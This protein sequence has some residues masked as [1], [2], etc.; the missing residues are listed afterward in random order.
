M[1]KLALDGQIAAARKLHY[2]L[3]D[4]MNLIFADGSPG[5][6]K[7]ILEAQNICDNIV[8]LPLHTVN[9]TVKQQLLGTMGN[10]VMAS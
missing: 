2:E 10:A 9:D 5:G 3:L 6:I 8:R 4:A 1:V 7:V